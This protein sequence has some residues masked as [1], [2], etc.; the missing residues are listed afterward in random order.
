V[1][2]KGTR[3][4]VGTPSGLGRIEGQRVA[5]RVTSGEGKLPHPWVTALLERPGGILLVATNG[6]GVVRR[7]GEGPGERWGRFPETDGLKVN[8]GAM[9]ADAAGHVWLGT[10]GKGLWRSDTSVTGFE[11]VDLP[12]PS[13][14]VFALAATADGLFVGTDE[15]LARIL[16]R[17]AEG[18]AP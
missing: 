11:H 2:M 14:D 16:P 9:I 8:A 7:S 5:S 1:P 12:L 15:G 3:L 18:D 13:P 6:G 17:R 4:W 10:Q